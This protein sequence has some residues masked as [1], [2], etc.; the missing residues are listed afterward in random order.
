MQRDSS[1][2]RAVS[3]AVLALALLLAA[4]A[5][6][7]T[8]AAQQDVRVADGHTGSVDGGR[9]DN[10]QQQY[11]LNYSFFPAT[12]TPGNQNGAAEHYALGL[13][14]DIR[15]HW[16]VVTSKEFDFSSCEAGDTNAFGVDRGN[17]D[18]GTKTDVS[19]L[20]SYRSYTSTPNQIQIAYYKEDALAGDPIR[21]NVEDEIVAKQSNCYNNPKEAGWYRVSGMINGSTKMDTNTD[22]TIQAGTQ[23]IYICE[24]SSRKEAREKLGPPPNEQGGSESSTP[25]PTATAAPEQTATAAQTA[26]A[27]ATA[28]ATQTARQQTAT[29]TV[30]N[31]KADDQTATAQATA[32]AGSTGDGTPA[33]GSQSDGGQQPS[34]AEQQAVPTTPTLAEGP[35]FGALLSVLALVGAALVALRRRQ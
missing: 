29:A 19:L 6:A 16:I 4:V 2:R 17:N 22:Y 23:Y 8:V 13:T 10:E 1:Y 33:P 18:S 9:E 30:S 5:P 24:C 34:T 21:I 27:T 25:E 31:R 11:P 26:T 14:E 28:Q 32:T 12:R 7:V 35:G 20:T 3:V 15:L